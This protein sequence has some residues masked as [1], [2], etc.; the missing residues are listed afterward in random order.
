V[1]QARSAIQRQNRNAR[2]LPYDAPV[3]PKRS[4]SRDTKRFTGSP[5]M[6]RTLASLA[7]DRLVRDSRW[8]A[9]YAAD[10]AHDRAG[11]MALIE[12]T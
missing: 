7:L 10:S 6:K 1:V 3:P 12:E 8:T 9:R 5:S 2:T 11:L 4:R